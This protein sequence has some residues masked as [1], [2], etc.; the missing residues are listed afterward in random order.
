[1]ARLVE[2]AI[3]SPPTADGHAAFGSIYDTPDTAVNTQEG[4]DARVNLALLPPPEDGQQLFNSYLNGPHRLHPF[5]YRPRVTH[6]LTEAYANPSSLSPAVLFRIHMIFAIGAVPLVRA[7]A[8]NVSPLDYYATAMQHAEKAVGLSNLE[9]IQAV[10]LILMFS[11]QHDIGS[12][13]ATRLKISQTLTGIVQS[14][15]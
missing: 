8:H 12:K 1:M 7:G 15:E 5:L 6:E 10:L 11:L 14:R 3:T 4:A 13:P 2:A 9:H